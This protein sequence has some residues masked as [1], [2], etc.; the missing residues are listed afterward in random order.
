MDFSLGWD[1][2]FLVERS[3]KTFPIEGSRPNIFLPKY[4][5]LV[6][7]HRCQ[8]RKAIVPLSAS[9]DKTLCR[10]DAAVSASS[11]HHLN[12]IKIV[13]HI[14]HSAGRGLQASV[15]NRVH[16]VNQ[17]HASVWSTSSVGLEMPGASSE[18][19]RQDHGTDLCYPAGGQS[20]GYSRAFLQRGLPAP[21]GHAGIENTAMASATRAFS[22]PAATSAG[23][24]SANTDAY[25]QPPTE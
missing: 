8:A 24:V 5:V 10:V 19:R 15:S 22:R 9:R 21:A 17:A 2:F 25:S 18:P 12:D 3:F 11:Q 14:M 7:S 23:G 13:K 16:P 6:Y 1:F 20:A 4:L